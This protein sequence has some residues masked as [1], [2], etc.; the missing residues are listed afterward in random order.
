MK[1]GNS[2]K[3][4]AEIRFEGQEN[5]KLRTYLSRLDPATLRQKIRAYELRSKQIMTREQICADIYSVV[6]PQGNHPAAFPCLTR[7]LDS[8]GKFY[9]ARWLR[10]TGD[11]STMADAWEAPADRVGA[12]RLNVQYEPLIYTAV[13]NPITAILEARI[14]VGDSFA[15]IEYR[16][17]MPI[18]AARIEGAIEVTGL[19]INESEKL[20]LVMKFLEDAFTQHAGPDESHRYMA[21]EIIVKNFFDWPLEVMQ[22]WGYPSIANSAGGGYNVCFRPEQAHNILRVR[23]VLIGTCTSISDESVGFETSKILQ[24]TPNQAEF[25]AVSA[26][27]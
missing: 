15:M 4:V 23:E 19:N 9:R 1:W 14:Q 27:K 2:V 7:R 12:G 8:G 22:G 3:S 18:D 5:S 10:N 24:P 16:S 11:F 25:F 6:M 13:E 17:Q 21:P 20:Q 26:E